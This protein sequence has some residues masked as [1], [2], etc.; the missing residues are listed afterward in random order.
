MKCIHCEKTAEIAYLRPDGTVQKAECI[1]CFAESLRD[2]VTYGPGT[3]LM[4]HG[5]V[6]PEVTS[7]Q[8]QFEEETWQHC[9]KL[10]A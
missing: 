8:P 2:A 6:M 9:R 10:K 3:G 7:D 5:F 1:D 4:A